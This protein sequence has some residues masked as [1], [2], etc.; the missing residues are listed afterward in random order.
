M[1]PIPDGQDGFALSRNGFENSRRILHPAV[2]Y[3]SAE[4]AALPVAGRAQ[5]C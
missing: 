4:L 3:F 2:F 5:F 1:R